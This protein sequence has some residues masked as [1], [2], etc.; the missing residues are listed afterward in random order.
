MLKTSPKDCPK[1]KLNTPNL[2][3]NPQIPMSTILPIHELEAAFLEMTESEFEAAYGAARPTPEQWD[4]VL[5][6]KSGVRAMN[7]DE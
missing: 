2:K 4:V 3:M 5:T 7:A 6:C 1:R